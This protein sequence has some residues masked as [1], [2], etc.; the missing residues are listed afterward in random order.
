MG[1]HTTQLHPTA[2]HGPRTGA[3]GRR[4]GLRTRRSGGA[5]TH[6]PRPLAGRTRTSLAA[7]ASAGLLLAACAPGEEPTDE[8]V[9]EETDPDEATE[10]DEDAA[11]EDEWEEEDDPES[12]AGEDLADADGILLAVEPACAEIGD[13]FTVNADGLE[14]DTNHTVMIDPEPSATGAFEA[15]V[16]GASDS[17]GALEVSATLG[18]DM[19]IQP[20][21]YQIELYTSEEGDAAEWLLSTDLEIA[22][23]C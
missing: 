20:G 9:D 11:T 2:D 16:L 12:Q 5:P 18:E 10:P 7:L 13:G 3:A 15:G 6:R 21:E 22:E 19:D 23:Q 4:S 8:A 14:P 17:E 1:R